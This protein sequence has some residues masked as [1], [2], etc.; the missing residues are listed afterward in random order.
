MRVRILLVAIL[1][2]FSSCGGCRTEGAKILDEGSGAE[3][4][5]P[6]W[7]L[8]EGYTQVEFAI[9]ASTRRISL[10]AK[11]ERF[12]EDVLPFATPGKTLGAI[13]HRPNEPAI[14]TFLSK[15]ADGIL[16]HGHLRQTYEP[17]LLLPDK[18]RVGMKWVSHDGAREFEII[19]RTERDTLFGPL[20]VWTLRMYDS[21]QD[22]LAFADTDPQLQRGSWIDVSFVE[23]YG[24]E[25]IA[26]DFRG[27]PSPQ[28]AYTVVPLEDRP[29]PRPERIALESLDDFDAPLVIENMHA[30]ELAPGLYTLSMHGVGF[31][32]SNPGGGVGGMFFGGW[33][34]ASL[35]YDAQARAIS[36]AARGL[37]NGL[38]VLPSSNGEFVGMKTSG[39]QPV[40]EENCGANGELKC[41]FT[42]VGLLENEDGVIEYVLRKNDSTR[43]PGLFLRTRVDNERYLGSVFGPMRLSSNL[44]VTASDPEG[45][46]TFIGTRTDGLLASARWDGSSIAAVSGQTEGTFGAVTRAGSREFYDV[47]PDGRLA[48]LDIADGLIE[49]VV[50]GDLEVPEGHFVEGAVVIEDRILVVTNSGFEGVDGVIEDDVRLNLG[51]SPVPGK[52]HIFTAKLP[53]KTVAGEHAAAGIWVEPHQAD[54]LVCWDPAF[55]ESSLEGWRLGGEP[56]SA[57]RVGA[58]GECVLLVR[59]ATSRGDRRTQG[60]YRVEGDVPGA[61]KVMIG[62]NR[63]WADRGER[64]WLSRSYYA[65]GATFFRDG[66]YL[67]RGGY[68]GPNGAPAVGFLADSGL[69]LPKSLGPDLVEFYEIPATACDDLPELVLGE[70]RSC[71]LLDGYEVTQ[72]CV[73]EGDEALLVEQ[74]GVLARE[75]ATNRLFL[76]RDGERAEVAGGELLDE[77]FFMEGDMVCGASMGVSGC[78]RAGSFELFSRGELVPGD[79]AP[80]VASNGV[81]YGASMD[82]LIRFDLG[83]MSAEA[84][85]FDALIEDGVAGERW[86]VF[87]LLEA[88]GEVYI[89]FTNTWGTDKRLFIANGSQLEEFE[90]AEVSLIEGGVKIW[91]EEELLIFVWSDLSERDLSEPGTVSGVQLDALRLPR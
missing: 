42:V 19:D 3:N 84:I 34:N 4:S 9:S 69:M 35:D 48:R 60:A 64:S 11:R 5:A 6:L 17:E 15:G 26:F 45:G 22:F 39:E 78:L 25:D 37:G 81:A 32:F 31:V 28:V 33:S 29:S 13:A 59:G 50:L 40:S 87:S 20:P 49:R 44:I 91:V 88:S 63:E 79:A 53:G 47:S 77:V 14:M 86:E 24:P 8:H 16:D 68:T 80:V 51:I 70:D 18:V 27:T 12:G 89:L 41:P 67:N 72:T 1:I 46:H 21:R 62:V 73:A 74:G 75:P 90:S 76:S 71:C 57:I 55:G 23:G 83:A 2:L 7:P 38:A 58:R 54:M 85:A 52:H 82:R 65:D 66:K 43:E 36:P 56:A 30:V 61:G 10:R